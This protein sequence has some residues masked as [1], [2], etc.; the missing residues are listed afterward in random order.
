ML[1]EDPRPCSDG[2]VPPARSG[3]EARPADSSPSTREASS[4]PQDWKKIEVVFNSL[5]QTE[6]NLYVGFWGEGKGTLWIDD[7][8]L[9]ELSLVNVLQAQGVPPHRQVRR[10]ARRPTRRAATSSRSSIPSSARFPSPASTSSSTPVRRSRSSSGSRIKTG[11][12]AARELVSPGDH[13][14]LAGDVLPERPQA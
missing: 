14:R 4:Q 12:T 5:D 8:E 2:L 6:V 7:L 9:E 11:D 1:G 13:A 10:T 3:L